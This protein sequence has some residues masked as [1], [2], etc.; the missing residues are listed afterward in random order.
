MLCTVNFLK[1]A[2]Y[3]F[4]FFSFRFASVLSHTGKLLRAEL[5][6][7]H[8]V[9]G[10]KQ[11]PYLK[12]L[13]KEIAHNIDIKKPLKDY[14]VNNDGLHAE[15]MQVLDHDVVND[16]GDSQVN[17]RKVS[18]DAVTLDHNFIKNISLDA[19]QCACHKS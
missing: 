8:E 16:I 11:I 12:E 17:L 14:L 10:I 3:R 13:S 1:L 18:T 9:G 7:V 5:P 6:H 15:L 2:Q 19:F 4:I